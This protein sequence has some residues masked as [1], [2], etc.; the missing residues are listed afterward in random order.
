MRRYIAV[1]ICL[2]PVICARASA[3]TSPELVPGSQIRISSQSEAVLNVTAELDWLGEVQVPLCGQVKLSGL[4]IDA[5]LEALRSCLKK[6]YKQMPDLAIQEISPRQVLVKV[7][8]RGETGKL[9]RV[10]GQRSVHSLLSVEGISLEAG[11]VVRLLSPYGIDIVASASDAEWS[12]PFRWRGGETVIVEKDTAENR[13]ESIDVLGEVRKP[14]K[15]G[16]SPAKT[17][18]DAIRDAQ[19]PTPQA[20]PD[21]VIVYR[22]LSGKRIETQWTDSR[23]K[24][25]PGDVLLV[26]A[27]REGSLDKGLRWTVSLLSIVNTLFLIRLS[28]R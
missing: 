23:I 5:A 17:I 10:A 26:P 22:T 2:L 6:F 4:I 19:G 11:R 7:G 14:G 8:M 15:F 3:S 21:T 12:R 9:A 24:I 13:Q 27:Q 18:L 16:Y 28:D 20:L 25:E 1:C